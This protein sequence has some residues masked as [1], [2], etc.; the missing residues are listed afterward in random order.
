M[1]PTDH[2]G[3]QPVVVP[4]TSIRRLW[5][6]LAVLVVS[7][8]CFKVWVERGEIRPFGD[9][10]AIVFAT[11]DAEPQALLAPI[12]IDLETERRRWTT[13]GLI[14][15]VIVDRAIGRYATFL[16]LASVLV[17]VAFWCAWCATR[18]TA[19]SV[20]LGLMT[21]FGT[22]FNYCYPNSSI[23]A[24]YP[25]W[26]YLLVNLVAVVKLTTG[27]SR[28]NRWRA[29]FLV[30]LVCTALCWEVWLDYAGFL[31]A[32][33]ATVLIWRWRH[34]SRPRW[35]GLAWIIAVTIASLAA[36]LPI[37][38]G[39]GGD[40]FVTAG[41]ESETIA[42]YPSLA[43]MVEDFLSNCFTHTYIAITNYLPSVFI[44]SN[45]LMSLGEGRIVELQHG[46]H[47]EFQHLTAQ[48]HVFFWHFYAGFVACALLLS[49]AWLA[50]R[51]WRDALRGTW[52]CMSAD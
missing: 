8:L 48:H 15:I 50:R 47:A 40:E 7:Q 24:F 34:D 31:L 26:I 36:Y 30:S 6:V 46:Y 43:L 20:T 33:A 23:L 51:C 49:M 19:A 10:P 32:G 12:K 39:A 5:V 28:P 9:F 4:A 42:T 35:R 3:G 2:A 52:C 29:V 1:T 37:R 11:L 18:S 13:T 38:M 21:G 45:S 27:C 14:P 16:L 44:A 25:L 22:Q 17:I 41:M